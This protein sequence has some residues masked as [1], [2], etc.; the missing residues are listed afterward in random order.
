M[1]MMPCFGWNNRS[2]EAM[3]ISSTKGEADNVMASFNCCCNF[4]S[5]HE[6]R[7]SLSKQPLRG[8]D[9]AVQTRTRWRGSQRY[10]FT[11][12]HKGALLLTGFG[13]AFLLASYA[14]FALRPID[15][16]VTSQMS[17]SEGSTLYHLWLKP[18]V[19]VYIKVYVFNVTNPEEF[20]SGRE[21]IRVQEVGPYIYRE[22]LEN[23]NVTFNPNNTITYIPKRK[24]VAEPEMSPRDPDADRIIVPNVA[25]LGMASMLHKSPALLNVGL[26]TLARYLDSQPLLNLTAHEYLWGYD[27]PLVRLASTILPNWI[28]FSKLGLMDRMFDEGENVVTAALS[29]AQDDETEVTER[30][31]SV[32][33]FDSYN[34]LTTLRQWTGGTGCSS[35]KGVREGVLYPR[36]LNPNDTFL[37]YR[38]AFCR[39]LPMVFSRSVATDQGFP[40]YWFRLPDNVFDSPDRNPENA[41]YCRP[42]VAPCLLS[43]LADITPC[44]YSIPVALSFPHFYKGDPRLLDKMEGLSPDPSKHESTFIIQPD[45][46]LPITVRTRMQ[47]NLAVHNTRVNPRVALFNNHTLPIFW[48]DWVSK[49]WVV[50]KVSSRNLSSWQSIYELDSIYINLFQLF[51]YLYFFLKRNYVTTIK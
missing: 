15:S 44:Y 23:T 13:A 18:P 51:T 22:I 35:L 34:G 38:K 50:V 1:R 9:D 2:S 12:F 32:Y 30:R 31:R 48:L 39:V 46:G 36:R 41:C 16:I 43:G 47:L 11:N 20:L 8:Q 4:P 37:I 29:G 5:C 10:S 24:V 26:A 19:N 45:L 6:C 3:K 14:I 49:M 42:D 21:K 25:L 40:A 17:L 28:P 33:S 7:D 27:D